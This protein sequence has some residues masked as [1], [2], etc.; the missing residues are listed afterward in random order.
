MELVFD[1]ESNRKERLWFVHHYA[2]WVK[3]VPN[4]VW[5]SQQTKFIDS[6]IFNARNSNLSPQE[7]LKMK[8]NGSRVK[9]KR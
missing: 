9:K 4:H 5:S 8:E 1:R 2:S 7:Y 6:L 3:K